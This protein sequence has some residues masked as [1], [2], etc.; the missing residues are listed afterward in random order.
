M[1]RF[2]SHKVVEAFKV[3]QVEINPPGKVRLMGTRPDDILD[4]DPERLPK[5]DI[6]QAIGGWAVH[7]LDGDGFISWSPAG[8]FEEGYREVDEDQSNHKGLPVHGYKPQSQRNV[9]AVNAMKRQEEIV[10]RMVDEMRGH[11]DL[12]GRWLAIGLTHLEQAFMA[13]NRSVFQ[14]GRIPLVGDDS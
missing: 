1:R 7:Y 10:L 13:I 6:K 5:G 9:D 2:R 11:L 4:V 14:P 8:P 12:D 3:I